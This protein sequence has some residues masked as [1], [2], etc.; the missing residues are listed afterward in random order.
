MQR[1][2]REQRRRNVAVRP[3]W[4]CGILANFVE[5][6]RVEGADVSQFA[7]YFAASVDDAS[8]RRRRKPNPGGGPLRAAMGL[9]AICGDEQCPPG[10]HG[11][12]GL[13]HRRNRRT[14]AKLD[15]SLDGIPA[16]KLREPATGSGLRWLKA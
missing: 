6:R 16:V 12:F 5:G 13:R 9:L 2:E 7:E 4:R 11:R 3:E 8:A 14:D 1:G 10:N 15:I